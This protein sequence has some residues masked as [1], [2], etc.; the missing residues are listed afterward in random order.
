MANPWYTGLT[1]P[2][3][4]DDDNGIRA[5]TSPS[6]LNITTTPSW[7]LARARAHTEQAGWSK[8]I[9]DLQR[10]VISKMKK[11]TLNVM[12]NNSFSGAESHI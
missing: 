7:Q 5:L 9:F 2:I 12:K 10:E 3:Q 8:K 6:C 11:G 1:C 4:E